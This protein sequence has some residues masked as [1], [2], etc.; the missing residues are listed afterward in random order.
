MAIPGVRSAALA[1]DMPLTGD[2][3]ASTM[4]PD[5]AG[6][7]D[8]GIR[9]YRHRVSPDFFTTLGI[10]IVNGRAFTWQDRQDAPLV[11]VISAAAAARIWGSENAVGHRFWLGSTQGRP[12]EI[13]GVAGTARFRDLSTD[14]TARASEPDVYFSY[15]QLTEPDLDIAVR[16]SDG[17]PI[18]GGALRAALAK[19]D[20]GLPLFQVRRLDDVVRQQTSSQRFVSALLSV[21]SAGALL[22]AAIGL[23]GFMAYVVSLSRREIAIRLALGADRTRVVL[24]IVRNGMGVALVGIAVGCAGAIIAGRAIQSLLFQTS[25][26]DAATLVVVGTLL[27]VVTLVATLLPTRRAASVDPQTALRAD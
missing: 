16:S 26:V 8:A 6:P 4:I 17:H 2:A 19:V 7:G 5:V 12:V 15:G 14:L 18:P 27:I 9:Y 3:S 22:L 21:F 23:Y 10:P 1:S 20:G 11:A 13:V 25:G 24:L